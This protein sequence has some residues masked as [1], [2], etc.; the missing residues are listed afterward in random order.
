[1]INAVELS[2]KIEPY[3]PI[4]FWRLI[5]PAAVLLRSTIFLGAAVFAL[6]V[7]HA[8]PGKALAA[9][10]V[11]R[12]VY[13]DR[14]MSTGFYEDNDVASTHYISFKGGPVLYKKLF[15][16]Q[17]GPESVHMRT[18]LA[19]AHWGIQIY[20]LQTCID[21]HPQQVRNI[22]VVRAGITC[23][24][25]HGDKPV[26]GIN[27]YYSR[28]NPTR[29]HAYVCAKCHESANISYST[30]LIH[31]PNPAHLNTMRTFPALFFVFWLFVIIA[32]GTFAVFLPHTFLW[33]F[34]ELLTPG[35][36][37]QAGVRIKRFTAV[38]RLFHFALMNSFIIQGSTGLSRMYI[39]TKWGRFLASL[40]GGYEGAL[41][42]HKW[43]GIFM[44]AVFFAHIFYVLSKVDRANFPKSLFG[45]DSLLPRWTDISQA[46]QH[47]GWFLGKSKL[48]RFDRWGYWEKF[49]YW[50]VFWGIA[51]LGSTGLIM[52]NAV[53]SSRYMQG[54]VINVVFWVHR[55][56]ALLAMA[57][58][59]IIHFFI[60]HL[61]RH[62]FPMD[63][64]MFEGSVDMDSARHEKPAWVA[65]MEKNGML[66]HVM[67]DTVSTGK[68][69]LFYV[70][71]FTVLAIGLFL[72]VGGIVNSPHITW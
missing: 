51:V 28:M 1:M 49:D 21:C 67:V 35:P 7:V 54:W 34:R 64:A 9:E 26:P 58:V 6:G 48:P 24:Q 42:V 31:E 52:L 19:D 37:K 39:E 55:I 72:L 12:R 23:R 10:E 17:Q 14:R 8:L 29:R 2:I 70:F 32:A 47:V 59:F 16:L 69:T 40:F 36:Q 68:R 62:N 33:G 65:R 22:H 11:M 13:S 66:E 27:Y 63:R 53:T 30:Y 15:A 45:P 57:H 50:A 41:I 46:V 38:Q 5:K 61:R 18:F 71:G 43:T 3:Q 4:K 56:E 44:V 20:R 25:C 60:A